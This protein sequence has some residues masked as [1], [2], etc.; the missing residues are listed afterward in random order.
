MIFSK[1]FK[2]NKARW[3]HKDS[4]IRITAISEDLTA[5]NSQ[6][7]EI[8]LQLL[9]E[10]EHE[11][12]RRAALIKLADFTHW[13][14]ASEHNS[15][16]KVK[17]FARQQ[18]SLMLQDQHEL[19]LSSE[20]KITFLQEQATVAML[21]P[22]LHKESDADLIIELYKKINK[23]QLMQQL[24]VQKQNPQVQL[25]F[26]EQT[27]ETAVLEK[28]LKKAV[29]DEV[30]QLITD[31]INQITELA[32]KPAK[33]KKQVQ[34]LL[35]KL[36][37]LKDITD[38][39][40]VLSKRE[41]LQN[42]WQAVQDDLACLTGEEQAGFAEKY[43]T[44]TNQLVKIFAPKE[45]AYQQ[46]LIEKELQKNKQI[47]KD[48]FAQEINALSQTLTTAV[49][50]NSALDESEF[51]NKL[52]ALNDK[53]AAS[54][55]NGQEIADYQKTIRQQQ[56]KLTK[57]PVIAQS[58]SDATHLISRLSQLALPQTI[59][60]LNER[61]PIFD[62]WLQEWK[63]TEKQ[64]DDVLPE[65]IK[66][67]YQELSQHWR[68]GLKPLQ[69]EQQ[70]LFRQVQKKMPEL[71]R[72]LAS[73]KYKASFGVFK[74]IK[75]NFERLSAS[76]Q[77]RLQRDFDQ[78]S[79]KIA[80]LS[81]WE[82]YIATPRKQ[83]LLD[84]VKQLIE[85]PIDNPNELAAKIKQYRK[86]WNSLGHAD[87]ELDKS[88]NHDFNQAVEQAF[89][90]CRLYFAEQ[91]NLREQNLVKRMEII[92]QAKAMS[93]ELE[94][95]P[96]DF[97]HLDAQL[98]KLNHQWQG[99]GEVDRAKYKSL[100]HDY[101]QALQPLKSA[102]REF[103]HD[104]I[105]EKTALIEKAQA[106][107]TATEEGGDINAAIEQVKGIQGK[108]RNVGYAGPRE[109][110]K[111]WQRFRAVND[112]LF[113]KRDLLKNEQ[114]QAQSAQQA[115]FE[116]QL[117]S[118]TAEFAQA[119]ELSALS[120]VK[121]KTQALLEQV[122]SIKPVIKAVANAVE[123]QIKAIDAAI[124]Q[125]KS[126]KEKQT[127]LT[128]FNTLSEIASDKITSADE[129]NGLSAFWQKKVQDVL[130]A[131]DVV[132]RKEKT[133]ELE[134]LAGVESPAELAQDRMQAQVRLMQEQMSSGGAVDLQQNFINWLQ[135]GR[136]TEQ[137]LDLLARIKG[138]Y[139]Q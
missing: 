96:V 54:I 67:A 52:T 117:Q 92:E 9:N 42:E 70:G 17:E 104:N 28:F 27:G 63:T 23:P 105:A 87:E 114:Q 119:Q 108:W 133:L 93:A 98:N 100:L 37:A 73:G 135:L 18:I 76:Q 36:L 7:Q 59:E 85:Q 101:T 19:K 103:H 21:E 120:A 99:T 3:Q 11:L 71:K 138:I 72:L 127:W 74:R 110:N 40:Q 106:Q 125:Q 47:A 81:D 123:G 86:V 130:A 109:E 33:V 132:D 38:Y 48:T 22:W 118:L 8:L 50:E 64:A 102:I 1:L 16:A 95:T 31:K 45:E 77:H 69:Q 26:V 43:Q 56:A 88:L 112:E 49:F 124:D 14:N 51:A 41:L 44:I 111:L 68:S 15:H 107:L 6:D 57:L 29:N 2:A 116:A 139:C 91:E 20:T 89:A 5:A 83:Q 84:E 61:Q 65:S 80:E 137:D 82:H 115:E 58:V 97:K 10:D 39:E 90:P 34:L 35:S 30:S 121:Q 113:K 55:L 60:E 129:L 24:F 79:E 128:L 126:D 134:I 25:F 75:G 53:I 122:V 136:L 62:A 32:Q 4:T 46:S 94:K 131:T 78:V 13:Q 12:V 66:A